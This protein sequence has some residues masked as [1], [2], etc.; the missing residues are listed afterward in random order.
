[1]C[2]VSFYCEDWLVRR[3][4]GAAWR[5]ALVKVGF[6]LANE[7]EPSAGCLGG[8][9]D[10]YRAP[11]SWAKATYIDYD[12]VERIQLYTWS[13]REY[14][15]RVERALIDAGF[16]WGKIPEAEYTKLVQPESPT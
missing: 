12:G 2:R 15:E 16:R 13:G 1:M 8:D 4:G 14:K 9:L 5:D 10:I 3:G 6:T 11:K 7:R